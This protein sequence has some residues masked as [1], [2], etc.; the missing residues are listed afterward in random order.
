MEQERRL[1]ELEGLRERVSILE[2]ELAGTNPQSI[3]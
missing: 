1:R 3:T 2:S